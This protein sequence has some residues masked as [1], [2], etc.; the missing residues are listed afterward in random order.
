MDALRKVEGKDLR[1][2]VRALQEKKENHW[3]AM[4]G[5]RDNEDVVKRNNIKDLEASEGT[6]ENNGEAK[7]RRRMG[8][9][10]FP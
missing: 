7:K 3:T 6:L 1:V 10:P 2:V 5:Q 8:R 9:V 4:G